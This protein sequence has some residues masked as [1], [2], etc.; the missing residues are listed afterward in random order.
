MKKLIVGVLTGILAAAV[1]APSALAASHH[2]TGEFSV[3]SECPLNRATITDC[4]YSKTEGGLVKLGNKTVPIE[5]PAYLQGGFEGEVP[6]IK[7]YGAENGDTLSKT[8][9]PVPGGL[10]GLLN[11]KEQTN[12]LIKGLCETALENGLTGVNATVE[13]T[14]PSKGLT[15]I[16]L[17]TENLIFREG[18]A[19]QLP[20]KIKLENPLLGNS[21]YVGSDKSPIVIPFTTGTSGSLTGAAGTLTFNGDY[22]IITITGAKLVNNT[23]AAPAASG[24]GGLLALV[25]DPVL[26]TVIGLPAASGKNSAIL[27]GSFKDS[28]PEYVI[29]SE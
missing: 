29:A 21:C 3:F 28:Q 19:L 6:N 5:N 16:Y 10:L 8:P 13:L 22:S 9:Q 26:N 11:C 18:T 15:N 2:P 4:V 20:V 27:E 17:N 12:L 25:V 14:G 24:C 1:F 23:F 7:F